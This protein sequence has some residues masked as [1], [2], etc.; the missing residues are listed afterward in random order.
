[1]DIPRKTSLRATD[2]SVSV[3][4]L[5]VVGKGLRLGDLL[6]VMVVVVILGADKV[7]LVDAAALRASLNGAIFGELRE[8]WSATA[9]A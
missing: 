9:S 4:W 3:L 5:N 2:L 6:G 8:I 7:H 1:M